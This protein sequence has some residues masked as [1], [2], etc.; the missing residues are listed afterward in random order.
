MVNERQ[1]NSHLWI[2]GLRRSGTTAIWRMFRNLDQ[3]TC[4]DEPFNPMLKTKLPKQH[5]KGTWDEFINLW[6]DD[7][8]A[9]NEALESI[10]LAQEVSP[11]ITPRQQ[12]FLHY[13]SQTPTIIDF[14]RLNFKMD[15]I[16][17]KF[18]HAVALFLYRSPVAFATSHI[19]NSENQKFMRQR[20]YRTM[21]FSDRIG[22]DSW[23]IQ[24]N[25]NTPYFKRLMARCSI[26][27]R[28]PL[29]KLKS[30]EKL[31]LFWLA[32]RR[33]GNLIIQK[34][35]TNRTFAASYED[36]I[37]GRSEGFE[38]ALETVG[39]D[40][41]RLQTSHLRQPSLG[42]RH[43]DPSWIDLARNAGFTDVEIQTYLRHT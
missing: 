37:A 8:V 27:P 26:I 39:I 16:L 7:H 6:N 12:A 33:F 19:I 32:A 36:I 11:Q 21:F 31:L 3:F 43:D 9:F 10:S 20:Y 35:N 5:H 25:M 4:Y 14:T 34:D 22:F 38:R 28:K 13:M 30:V 17:Q 2:S 24:T 42:H 23:G 40:C 29:H 15:D 18:P 41:S 1:E